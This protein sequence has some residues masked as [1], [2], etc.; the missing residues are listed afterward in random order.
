MGKGAARPQVEL[1]GIHDRVFADLVEERDVEFVVRGGD[2]PGMADLAWFAQHRILEV[3]LSGEL[4]G[5]DRFQLLP[6]E[7]DK[8]RPAI[9][10]S[11]REHADN[12]RLFGLTCHWG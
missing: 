3:L 4:P 7:R 6:V 9:G 1:T 12:D 10:L 11:A 8:Q 2:A 5:G